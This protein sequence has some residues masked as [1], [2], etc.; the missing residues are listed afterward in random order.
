MNTCER[1]LKRKRLKLRK[2]LVESK[3]FNKLKLREL[4]VRTKES[5]WKSK[6]GIRNERGLQKNL[7]RSAGKKLKNKNKM[8]RERI[9]R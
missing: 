3:R 5:L 4:K 2:N 7:K 9:K 6:R 1:K 8:K